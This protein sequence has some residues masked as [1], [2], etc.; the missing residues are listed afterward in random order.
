MR[1]SLRTSAGSRKAPPHPHAAPAASTSPRTRGEVICVAAQDRNDVHTCAA[2][3]RRIGMMH[4]ALALACLASCCSPPPAHAAP[5]K[6][7]HIIAC[8]GPFAKSVTHTSLVKAFGARN[9]A[10]QQRR[11]RRR[12]N[13]DSKRDLSA[14]QGPP[15]RG[16]V[17]RRDAAAQSIGDPHRN[18][19]DMAHRTRHPPR[20]DASEIEALNGRPFKL[21]GFGFDYGGTTLD[22][23]GGALA[24]QAG[25]CT[26]TLRFTMREG[27]E[28]CRGLWRRAE[29]HV[30]RR[31]RCG[32][33]R[34]SSMRWG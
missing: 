2:C 21:Y 12:R 1:G 10:L 17:D 7:E 27:R 33:P 24:T 31:R 34:R 25:G 32:K 5:K 16:A 30:G 14:R 13:A 26:L 4:L 20:H 6:P 18:G 19:L 28:Q 9:V 3:S 15:H 23:N 8:T 11:H 22:W 29:L